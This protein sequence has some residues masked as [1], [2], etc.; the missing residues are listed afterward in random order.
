LRRALPEW[1]VWTA[2]SVAATALGAVALLFLAAG[3]R[4]SFLYFQ[5]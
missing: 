4:Q 3:P 2:E 1:L 5:F